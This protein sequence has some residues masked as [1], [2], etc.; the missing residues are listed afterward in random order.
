MPDYI[1]HLSTCDT[2]RKIIRELQ[3]F[4]TEFELHDIKADPLNEEQIDQLARRAGGYEALINKRAVLWKEL[5]DSQKSGGEQAFRKL[6]LQHYTFLKR[7]VIDINGHLFVG[8]DKKT[9]EAAKTE[10][11]A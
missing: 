6:L 1:Y 5:S 11:G 10:L 3:A 9:I 7:P 8:N 2:C 4:G